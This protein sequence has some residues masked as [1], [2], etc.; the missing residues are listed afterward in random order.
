SVRKAASTPSRSATRC[1]SAGSII[2]RNP[3]WPS[4]SSGSIR[5]T[6]CRTL[7]PPGD[8]P[9]ID[10]ISSPPNDGRPV[11]ARASAHAGLAI[12]RDD[13]AVLGAQHDHAAALD[14]V[15]LRPGTQARPQVAG[16]DAEHVAD[17]L[18]REH[19]RAILALDPRLRVREE[20]L[21]L[22]VPRAT[23]LAV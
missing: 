2:S 1:R 14:A 13:R 21:S 3:R 7:A 17:V 5:R 22:A 20:R 8:A 12:G 11:A 15:R 9:S 4:A 10:R 18:E 6:P 19:P 23:Q 16:V